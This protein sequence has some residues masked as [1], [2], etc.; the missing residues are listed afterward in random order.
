MLKNYC[1]YYIIEIVRTT[2]IDE[3]GVSCYKVVRKVSTYLKKISIF[4]YEKNIL[5]SVL[6]KKYRIVLLSRK[7]VHII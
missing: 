2:F 4:F 1:I 7:K 6:L 3:I 5:L